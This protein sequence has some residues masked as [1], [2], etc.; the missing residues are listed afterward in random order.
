[1]LSKSLLLDGS[2]VAFDVSGLLWS[3]RLDVP[4]GN[5]SLLNQRKKRATD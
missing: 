4:D 3:T 5:S 2:I 1:M